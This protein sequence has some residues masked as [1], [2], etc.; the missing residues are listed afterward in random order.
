MV[1]QG[2]IIKVD[3]N[4][5]VGHEQAGYRPAVIISNNFFNKVTGLVIACP[6]TNA[7]K[8]F[9]LHIS[10]DNRTDTTGFILC[11]HVKTLDLK[12]RKYK[13]IEKL[14]EDILK[15][16]LDTVFSEIDII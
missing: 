9:P 6:I 10:L 12:N 16:V 13:I 5:Q 4:P 2:D 11:Q 3:F 15:T 1:E 14:P 7:N 8:I